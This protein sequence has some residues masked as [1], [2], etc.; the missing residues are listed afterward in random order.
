MHNYSPLVAHLSKYFTINGH[1]SLILIKMPYEWLY[2][3]TIK[4]PSVSLGYIIET[5]ENVI[6]MLKEAP[7]ITV[8]ICYYT[9]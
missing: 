4:Q 6:K 7:I 2:N 3:P 8:S 1:T 5:L 9:S